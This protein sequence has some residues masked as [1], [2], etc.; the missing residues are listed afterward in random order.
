MQVTIAML[1][2]SMVDK[3]LKAYIQK[4]LDKGYSKRAVINVLV[5]HGYDELYINR[6]FIKHSE[7]QFV[8]GYA[9]TALIVFMISILSFSLIPAESQQK[10]TGYA[11]SI[12]EKAQLNY[13]M[14]V[15]ALLSILFLVSLSLLLKKRRRLHG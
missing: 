4:H 13:P 14:L 12:Q 9:L 11:A 1:S 3:K 5:N 6:L 15:L 7:T 10:I 8:K 2:K